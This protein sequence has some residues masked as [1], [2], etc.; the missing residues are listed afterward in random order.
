MKSEG[1]ALT[2]RRQRKA[3]RHHW[4]IETPHGKTSRG[5]C[6]RCGLNRRFPNAAESSLWNSSSA[7]LGR[8]SNRRGVARPTEIR[9]SDSDNR[10]N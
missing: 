2:E 1:V 4:I 7:S 9:R 6:K 3:C 8:W 10:K 5:F